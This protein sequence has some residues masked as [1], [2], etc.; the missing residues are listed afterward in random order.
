MKMLVRAGCMLAATS[1]LMTACSAHNSSGGES[2]TAD[3]TAKVQAKTLTVWTNSADPAFVTDAYKT[4]GKKFGVKMN[5]VKISADGFE[6]QVQT[7]WASG[8]RPDLLEYQAT[9]LFW[10]LNPAANMIDMSDMPFVKKSGDLYD[11]AGSYK[12]KVYAA[13]TGTPSLFGLF[14][15][16]KVL[17]DAG[18]A[19]PKT[20]A[21][22]ENACTTLKKKEPDVVPLWESG[23]SQWPTQILAGL[24]YL[25]SEEKDAHYVDK[26]LD[27]KATL[28]DPDGPFVAAMTEYK[29]LQKMGCFNKDATTAKFEDSVKAVSEGSAAMVALHSGLVSMIA[30][31][32]GGS[33]A[34]ASETV[35]WASPSQ[36]D[37]TAVWAPN[38]SGTWFVPK[39]DSTDKQSTALAFIQWITGDGYK[40]YVDAQQSFPILSGATTPSNYPELQKEIQKSYESSRSLAFNTNLVGFNAQFPV[41]ASGLLSGQY[42]PAEVGKLAQKALAQGAKTANLAGW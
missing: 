24:M 6:S 1:L 40:D 8:D 33:A 35:G 30:Q 10:A 32:F 29:K 7:K 20:Y 26:V 4:F 2:V 5:I 27:H 25:G 11:S 34:K 36:K 38:V 15:N 39:S 3:G 23:G 22:L 14:Y 31:Q 21:D 13:V 37:A 28:D 19:V 9:S 16:K 12:D 42:T 17:A 41:Y 18:L